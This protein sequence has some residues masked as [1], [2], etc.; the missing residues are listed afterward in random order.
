MRRFTRLPL[1]LL[2]HSDVLIVAN[3][4]G[5]GLE[6]EHCVLLELADIA[7]ALEDRLIR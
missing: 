5:L 3:E 2:Q 1:P 7:L 4:V 6:K